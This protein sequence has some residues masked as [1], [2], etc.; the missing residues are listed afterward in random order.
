MFNRLVAGIAALVHALCLHLSLGK[1]TP[2]IPLAEG[3]H[4]NLEVWEVDWPVKWRARYDF[5]EFVEHFSDEF[6]SKRPQVTLDVKFRLIPLHEFE[7]EVL[8]GLASGNLPD[9]LAGPWVDLLL[10]CGATV[11]LQAFVLPQ[12]NP[13]FNKGA[14]AAVTV[15]NS[16]HAIPRWVDPRCAAVNWELLAQL[17]LDADSVFRSGWSI[18]EFRSLGKLALINL[19]DPA[20]VMDLVWASGIEPRQLLTSADVLV[21]L[22]QEVSQIASNSRGQSLL[23][24]FWTGKA[25]AIAPVGRGFIRHAL[26]RASLCQAG[27]LNAS[28]VRYRL[29][30]LPSIGQAK[31]SALVIPGRLDAVAVSATRNQTPQT[32]RLACE[33][34]VAYAQ[35]SAW[36]ASEVKALPASARDLPWWHLT[37]GLDE[38]HWRFFMD[39]WNHLRV[40]SAPADATPQTLEVLSGLKGSEAKALLMGEISPAQCVERLL[41]PWYP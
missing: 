38:D 6:K 40:E 7:T 11:P 2:F 8:K 28:V 18:Q 24:Q 32:L 31:G 12:E 14:L 21:E 10:I 39:C 22:L 35:A 34:A 33:F 15:G 19:D 29:V 41:G 27:E 4:Y 25:A 13:L 3:G 5:T 17:G 26:E 9:V 37:S 36:V 23:E 1:V 30:P 16:L 20:T